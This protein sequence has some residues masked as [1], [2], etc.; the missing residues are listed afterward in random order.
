MARMK[1]IKSIDEKIAETEM[2][3][4]KL[5][6]RCDKA[7]QELDQLYTEKKKMEDMTNEELRKEIERLRLETEYE[8]LNKDTESEYRRDI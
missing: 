4:Q 3:L 6:E 7:A 2:K 1:S 8:R 5:K